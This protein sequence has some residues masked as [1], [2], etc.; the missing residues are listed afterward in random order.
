LEQNKWTKENSRIKA[1]DEIKRI[2]EPIKNS[3]SCSKPK[4]QGNYMLSI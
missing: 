4:I 1:I 3:L 2:L